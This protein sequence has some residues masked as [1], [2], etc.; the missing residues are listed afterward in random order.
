M[1]HVYGIAKEEAQE[2]EVGCFQSICGFFSNQIIWDF[3]ILGS[4]LLTYKGQS[5]KVNLALIAHP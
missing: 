3:F 4:C 2:Y 1:S 5:L